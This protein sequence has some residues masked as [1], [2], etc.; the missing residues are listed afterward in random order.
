MASLKSVAMFAVLLFSLLSILLFIQHELHSMNKDVLGS[1]V[2][3]S[4]KLLF[5]DDRDMIGD[6]EQQR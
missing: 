4:F 2:S 3:F 6:N 1:F 5:T